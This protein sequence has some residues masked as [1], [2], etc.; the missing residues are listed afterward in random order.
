MKGFIKNRMALAALI[1]IMGIL[2]FAILAPVITL[3]LMLFES[4]ILKFDIFIV[5]IRRR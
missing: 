1:F 3:P 4:L 5:L 2:V